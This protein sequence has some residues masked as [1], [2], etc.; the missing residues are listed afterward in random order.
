MS[1]YESGSPPSRGEMETSTSLGMYSSIP[2][3]Q[4]RKCS[5]PGPCSMPNHLNGTHAM[6]S[7]K[8]YSVGSNNL[9]Y[10]YQI[11]EMTD[12]RRSVHRS[13]D[14]T[15]DFPD[16]RPSIN[17]KFTSTKFTSSPPRQQNYECGYDFGE[18]YK[19]LFEEHRMSTASDNGMY[20]SYSNE[21]LVSS[22]RS[23]GVM[24]YLTDSVNSLSTEKTLQTTYEV[25]SIWCMDY[26]ENLIVI[27][28]A[29]GSLEFW[30]G[31]T[32]KFKV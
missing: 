31:T 5:P 7:N 19:Q 6:P 17:T 14:Q 16:L 11:N 8:R 28:C 22:P 10:D 4:K 25:S 29:N 30:E 24:N 21:Q 13:L 12:R 2:S 15:F 18:Q 9:D 32:G 20:K 26:Q 23:L 1:D 27:G 3:V